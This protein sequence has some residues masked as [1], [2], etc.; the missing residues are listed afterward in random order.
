MCLYCKLVTPAV[1]VCVVGVVLFSWPV[2]GFVNSK[3][4]SLSLLFKKY[5][6]VFVKKKFVLSQLDYYNVCSESRILILY[7]RE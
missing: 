1:S 5:N 6:Q 4:G 3:S 2:D 7:L